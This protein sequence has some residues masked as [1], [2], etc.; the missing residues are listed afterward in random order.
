MNTKHT[1]TP[2]T[3]LRQAD[4]APAQHLRCKDM[5]GRQVTKQIPC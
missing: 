2:I 4:A 3:R 5:K 1:D